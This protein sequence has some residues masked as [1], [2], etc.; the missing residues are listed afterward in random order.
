M[1]KTILTPAQ[2]NFLELVEKQASITNN[3]YLTGGTALSEFYLKHR[4]SED[5]DLF[6]EKEINTL[7]IESF[8]KSRSSKLG[9]VKINRSKFLGLFTYHL[10]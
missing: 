4:L 6:S 2:R 10:Q 9:V 8:L 1:A 7:P 5:I 3:F